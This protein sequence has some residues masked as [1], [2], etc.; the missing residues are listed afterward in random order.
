MGPGARTS[1]GSSSSL[2]LG[3]IAA[4][5]GWA[6]ATWNPT[7]V[8]I[9][10]GVLQVHQGSRDDEFD[11]RD[12]HTRVDLGERPGSPSW[13]TTVTDLDGRSVVIGARQ[14]KAAHFSEI[15]KYHRSRMRAPA[16]RHRQ[17]DPREDRRPDPCH[18]LDFLA[19]RSQVSTTVS[20][21]SD[22]DS[23]PCSSSHSAMSGWSLG[24]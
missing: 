13:R 15:V 5:A 8:A 1:A 10:D 16:R 17:Q 4:A 21:L 12:P 3:A 22:I 19:S 9:R 11:L 20:G 7:V 6:L 24:P 23:M 2:C 18:Q 14:V